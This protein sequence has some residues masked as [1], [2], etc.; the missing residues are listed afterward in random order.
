MDGVGRVVRRLCPPRHVPVAG[1]VF[2]SVL[3]MLAAPLPAAAGGSSGGMARGSAA[4]AAPAEPTVLFEEDFENDPV[5]SGAVLLTDYTGAAPAAHTYTADPGWLKGCNGWI[6]NQTDSAKYAPGTKDCG[7]WWESQ[8]VL[9]NALGQLNGAA[10]P[11]ENHSVAAFTVTVPKANSVEFETEQTIPVTPGRFLTFAVS[12]AAMNC[13][14]SGPQ[15]KFFLMG[16]TTAIPATAKA[17]NPCTDKNAKSFKVGTSSVK[18]VHSASDAPVLF[19]GSAVGIRMVNANGSSA[20]N[21][22]AF[23]D[24]QLLDVTPSV[25]KAFTPAVV[26]GNGTSTLT[27]TV[28]NTSDLLSKKGWSFTDNL[29]DGLTVADPASVKTTC[30]NGS[31]TA[32]SGDEAIR[33]K[34]E[35]AAGQT[36]CTLS[37]DV[38][39]PEGEYENCPDNLVDVRGLNAPTACATVRFADPAYTIE[40]SS[41]PASGGK[42]KPGEKVTY[43]V[44]VTNTGP[45]ATDA[46]VT[47]DLRKVLDDATYNKDAKADAGVPAYTAPKLTWKPSLQPGASAT[48]TYSVTLDDPARGDGA[49]TNAVTGSDASNCADGT[50]E[51][52]TTTVTVDKPPRGGYCAD[53]GYLVQWNGRAYELSTFDVSTGT[54]TAIGNLGTDRSNNVSIGYSQLDG[55]LYG[56]RSTAGQLLRIDPTTG[57]YTS[58]KITGMA[59]LGAAIAATTPDGSK[60][61]VF[62]H[63]TAMFYVVDIDT[64]NPTYASVLKTLDAKAYHG[65][66]DFAVNPKDGRLYTVAGDGTLWRLDPETAAW[67]DLGKQLPADKSP[68]TFQTFADDMGTFYFFGNFGGALHQLD[69]SASSADS[70]IT[71]E[72]IGEP[73]RLGTTTTSSNADAAGCLKPYDLGDAPDSYGTV[74]GKGPFAA[75]D[76][77]LMIGKDVSS[78]REARTPGTGKAYD[79]T[80]D[81]LDDGVPTWPKLTENTTSYQVP[82][83]VTNTTGEAA[84][85]TG[86]V[87]FDGSGTFDAREVTSVPVPAGATSVELTWTGLGANTTGKTYARLWL[88]PG[89]TPAVSPLG[90]ADTARVVIGEIEDSPLTVEPRALVPGMTI[91]K[92]ADKAVVTPGGVLTYTVALANTGE[93]ALNNITVTDD[94]SKVLDDAALS[95]TP[96]ASSGTITVDGTTATWKG[97]I[98]LGGTVILTY[99]VKAKAA[100]SG[101]GK[102]VNK[103]TGPGISNCPPDSTD[104]KCTTEAKVSAVEIVK[105]IDNPAPKP[106]DK[107]TYTIRAKNTGQVAIAGGSFADDLVK[108]LDDATYNEDADATSG[109]VAHAEPTLT[110]TGDIP[111]DGT[112]TLTYSV[113]VKDPLTGDKQLANA[114]TSDIPGNNCP[115]GSSDPKCRTTT[116]LPALDIVKSASKTEAKPGDT[117]TYKVVVTNTGKAP[118]KGA[119]VTDDLTEVLDDAAYNKNAKATSGEISYEEPKV[120]WTGIVPAGATVTLTYSVKID[121]PAEGDLK[122]ANAVTGPPGSNCP[123]DSTDPK[124][125]ATTPIASLT[126]K[127]SSD[128]PAPMP[129]DTVT[130]IV[131]V[132]NDSTE[133][134]YPG[135]VF[136]D[137]LTKIVDDAAYNKDAEATAG[138]VAY[139]EPTLAWKGDVPAGG[140]VTVTYSVTV[141]TPPAGDKLLANAVTSDSPGSNCP[142]GSDDPDCSTEAGIPTYKVKKTA[143][144]ADPKAGDTLTYTV[145]VTNDGQADYAGATFTDDLTT[146]LDDAVYNEDAEATSGEVSYDEPELTWTGDLAEGATATV[147]YTF[148]VSAALNGDGKFVNGVVG[149]SNCPEGSDDPD[150]STVLPAPDYDFG[151]APDSYGTT[152]A[153]DGAYHEVADELRIGSALN[154][155]RDGTPNRTA[156][157][158]TDDDGLTA[159]LTLYQHQERY[160][161]KVPVTNRT[162]AP[163]V[164]AGWIDDNVNGIFE[165]EEM[166]FADVPDGATEATLT[167]DGLTTAEPVSTFARLRLYG[168]DSAADAADRAGKAPKDPDATGFGGTGEI[169]DHTVV[170]APAHLEI[171]KSASPAEPKP[172]GKVRY[173]VTVESS[174][175]AQYADATFSDDLTKV[176]DDAA[177]NKDAEATVGSVSYAKAKLTW[178]GDIPAGKTVTVRYSVTVDKPVRGD[179]KL[180]NAVTG[181]EG[182]NCEPGSGDPD[183]T[184]APRVP[185]ATPTPPKKPTPPPHKPAGQLP[186]TG[187][188]D[189]V[190]HL[191]LAAVL[192]LGIGVLL[193]TAAVRRGR[194]DTD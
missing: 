144:P 155:E 98:P 89:T 137:D 50:E 84:T 162:G 45:V 148:T 56:F 153:R 37:V 194:R 147:T 138:T 81:T 8:R 121:S 159:T 115:P 140:T 106:G 85:L 174:A 93:T 53:T 170:V 75:I 86:W 131:T 103:V 165:S 119:T 43:T 167:W 25:E 100:G 16:G 73:M 79:A 114:V 132:T 71:A 146:V 193:T 63:Q 51:G 22:A 95:G 38:T 130:Y 54:K 35:L 126:F 164:L 18:A 110:W 7:T 188:S 74:R 122:L 186:K 14:V 113:T 187:S 127:K 157:Q 173:T 3:A 68:G 78:E 65:S 107:V 30:A 26:A 105:A 21:D 61:Y 59:T 66:G 118:Y 189:T 19:D 142:P 145:T 171:T 177:Y 60:M 135:A 190:G 20:G 12:S 24:I 169:E 83:A 28:T 133:A 191:S 70:L 192:T 33:L 27:F 124:C 72:E 128:N 158:S 152:R 180:T 62:D 143:S 44:K 139:T 179:R 185:P 168:D 92:A 176:L 17:I 172:G 99:K 82:V 96:T 125:T 141:N 183:C 102:L 184:S 111:V 32:I 39:A 104:P 175:P 160:T 5:E 97:D 156:A 23:D 58:T 123:P 116:D 129:G 9:P 64:D 40:K 134:A 94:L 42:A 2:G 57:K 87:D 88:Q 91:T 10:D 46:P 11:T 150:C 52:C 182:S 178:K 163:A 166:V 4:A 108:V 48:L 69:L 29:P 136:T 15:L 67:T 31:V 120:T 112:V 49:L 117:V 101:D 90:G 149:G 36:S 34:G 1:L 77:R 55:Y 13:H 154:A 76:K 47:D 109:E 41:A 151:D 6:L 161:A 181:P 80:G